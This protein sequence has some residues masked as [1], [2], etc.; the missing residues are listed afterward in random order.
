VDNLE[1]TSN[2]IIAVRIILLVNIVYILNGSGLV[3]LYRSLI[4]G[5]HSRKSTLTMQPYTGHHI[6]PHISSDAYTFREPYTPSLSEHRV[7]I[8]KMKKCASTRNGYQRFSFNIS[9]LSS[10][11]WHSKLMGVQPHI[12]RLIRL[13]SCNAKAIK[14]NLNVHR[15][16]QTC[17]T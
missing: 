14:Q 9:V 4:L 1:P 2:T 7:V 8:F 11:R 17:I 15:S 3:E 12:P 10:C 16:K 6:A 5:I 13:F